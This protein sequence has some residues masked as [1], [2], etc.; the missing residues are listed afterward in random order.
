MGKKEESM[1][2]DIKFSEVAIDS[3]SDEKIMAVLARSMRSL[4]KS[5]LRSLERSPHVSPLRSPER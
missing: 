2:R 1:E 4:L 5:T 3:L